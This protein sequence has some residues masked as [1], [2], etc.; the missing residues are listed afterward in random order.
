MAIVGWRGA[1][2]APSATNHSLREMREVRE[3]L[4]GRA[5]IAV[6]QMERWYCCL[7]DGAVLHGDTLTKRPS[8]GIKLP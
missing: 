5:G 8:T 3:T 2:L 6:C 1:W 4:R 7:P